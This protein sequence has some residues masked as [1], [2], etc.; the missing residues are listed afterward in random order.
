MII[1]YYG[2]DDYRLHVELKKMRLLNAGNFIVLDGGNLN[3]PSELDKALKNDSLF[4]SKRSV[5]LK[6]AFVDKKVSQE[7]A[8]VIKKNNLVNDGNISLLVIGKGS[9]K[10]LSSKH[11]ELWSL[12]KTK[13]NVTKAFDALTGAKL[14]RWVEDELLERGCRI[15]SGAL[16]LLIETAGT[17]SY[18]LSQ[19]IEKLAN[20]KRTGTVGEY[21]VNFLVKGNIE[22]NTF[23]LV[24][25]FAERNKTRAFEL[26]YQSLKSGNDPFMIFGALTYQFRNILM[27]SDLAAR[28][29]TDISAKTGLHPYVIK[30]SLSQAKSFTSDKLKEIHS[31]LHLM[32][33]SSK[34]GKIDITLALNQFLLSL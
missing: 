28:T 2:T 23:N 13:D 21:D 10:D 22:L 26:L 1:F 17:D 33:I 7:V 11:K 30:K 31:K 15:S 18:T 16:G 14:A 3:A 20:F 12:L 4:D 6:D 32:D 19:E 29:S 34:S 8:G 27:V 24:D 9:E 25:A 5:I